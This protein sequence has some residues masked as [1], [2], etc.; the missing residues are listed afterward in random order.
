MNNNNQRSPPQSESYIYPLELIDSVLQA[1]WKILVLVL[2]SLAIASLYSFGKLKIYKADTLIRVES[3][4]ATIPGIE[5]LTGLNTDDTSVSTEIEILKSRK[6]LGEAV[7]TLKLDIQAKP[8]KI[9]VLSNLYRRFLSNNNDIKKIPRIWEIFDNWIQKY[10]WG[11]EIIKV[12]RLE[13]PIGLLNQPLTLKVIA[14]NQYEILF[15]RNKIVTG[16]IGQTA[17]S[18]DGSFYIFVSQLRGLPGTEFIVEKLSK[19]KATSLLKSTIKATEKGKNTGIIELSVTG[20]KE[21]IIIKILDQI[22]KTYVE[23]NMS[24]SAEEAS[25]ALIFLEEQIKPV[26]EAVD[27]SEANL[28][29]YQTN[30]N[31]SNLPQEAQAILDIAVSIDA[32][33]QKLALRKEELILKYTLN[34]PTIQANNAQ[35]AQ[36]KE[37]KEK[38]LIKISKLPKSQQKLFELER[39]I[40]V[41][42]AIYVNLLNKIQEFKIAK[43]S[44]IGNAYVIDA[45][46][47]DDTFVKPNLKWI[48]IIGGLLGLFVGIF[49]T[50][51]NKVL[52]PTIDSPE[53]LELDTGIPVYAT[54]PFSKSVKLIKNFTSKTSKQKSLLAIENSTD[55]A[56]ESLRSLRTSIHFA[57]DQADN[58]II[59]VTSPSPHSGKSFISSNLAAVIADTNQRILLIDADMRKG[60]LH[61]LLNFGLVPGLSDYIT[62]RATIEE[63]TN[64]FEYDDKIFDVI[65]FGQ[66]PPNPSELLMNPRFKDLL[67]EVSTYYDLVIIDSPPV[68]AVTDPTIIGSHTGVVFMVV[69]A[70]IN[71]TREIERA[72]S[73]LSNSGITTKGLIF[74]GYKAKRNGYGYNYNSYYSYK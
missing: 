47:I 11:H 18:D 23:Q 57:L 24:R 73:V 10:A 60:Y 29:F 48:L 58:N 44:S 72:I 26:K 9:P 65:T 41:S 14:N 13:L 52:R 45:A 37:Q 20:I 55:L 31:T 32:D 35:E 2:F 68:L 27:K 19:R 71:N 42:N 6:N 15:E 74:N 67:T 49:L 4:K 51:L 64:R 36:L 12:D 1:K 34:H 28:S 21:Q 3:Q 56:I 46:D 54:I 43:A 40:Q 70:E 22:T 63:V 50:L 59:M 38:T 16:Y 66:L 5:E 69:N 53:Q 25:N 8:R 33:L 39:D 7:D 17:K 62:S 30:N 61:Q